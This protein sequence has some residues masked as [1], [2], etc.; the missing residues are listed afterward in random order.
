MRN[1]VL[2]ASAVLLA[3]CESPTTP[4]ARSL[5]VGVAPRAAVIQNVRREIVSAAINDCNGDYVPG[6]FQL[7]YL[8]GVTFDAA[9]GLHVNVHT[10]IQGQVTNDVTGVSYSVMQSQQ[11]AFNVRVGFEETDILHF[12]M[13]ARG[14]QPNEELQAVLH[15]TVTPT[16]DVS[17]F[18]DHF[19]IHCQ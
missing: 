2:I 17:V 19:T 7:H 14:P 10:D 4:A 13:V 18:T 16:G 6:V 12:N 1:I 15:V 8:V 9:G 5:Q 11:T 3:A